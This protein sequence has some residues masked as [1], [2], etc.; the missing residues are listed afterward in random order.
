MSKINDKIFKQII[1]DSYE[2]KVN[3]LKERKK[4]LLD[5]I[6]LLRFKADE[7]GRKDLVEELDELIFELNRS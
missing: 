4:E 3:N 6:S 1:K 7:E 2:K 5:E